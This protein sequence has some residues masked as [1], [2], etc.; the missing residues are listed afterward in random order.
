MFALYIILLYMTVLL[1]IQFASS[2]QTSNQRWI[3]LHQPNQISHLGM[4]FSFILTN[5]SP[6]IH[7]KLYHIFTKNYTIYSPNTHQ[8]L[9]I[10]HQSYLGMKFIFFGQTFHQIVTK[11][12]KY[13]TNQ[14][15][16]L[17]TT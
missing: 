14:I 6:N 17:T 4:K 1:L 13:Y 16:H 12:Y 5:I 15:R 11:Y 8:I 7:Q 2:A 9:Q 10:L 3:Q